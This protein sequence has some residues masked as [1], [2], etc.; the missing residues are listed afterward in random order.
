MTNGMK[1]HQHNTDP[2]TILVALRHPTI[3]PTDDKAGLNVMPKYK[4]TVGVNH[5][6]VLA[7]PSHK[8]SVED[9]NL[10]MQ[11]NTAP[12]ANKRSDFRLRRRWR[13]YSYDPTVN[14]GG[15]IM[16]ITSAVAVPSG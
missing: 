6:A 8:K 12:K 9:P 10:I 16:E 11:P 13:M 7:M 1:N 15:N 4:L 3:Y 2:I 14:S 5:T